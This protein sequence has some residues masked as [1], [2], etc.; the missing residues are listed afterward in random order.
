MTQDRPEGET[1]VPAEASLRV[2]AVYDGRTS[3]IAAARGLV[4]SVLEQAGS[5]GRPVAERQREAARLVVSELVTNSARYAPGPCT[6]TLEVIGSVLHIAVS[7]TSTGQPVPQ[8]H[9]PERIG[10]HGLEI[11]LALSASVDSEV[12]ARGKTVRA[13]IL[14][15]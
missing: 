15:A 4:M 6:V 11:V 8:P 5:Q 12:T 2:S 3:M 9:G 14:L 1:T 13:Q 10:Q 7:D